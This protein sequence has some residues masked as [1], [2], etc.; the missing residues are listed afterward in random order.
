MGSD[1]RAELADYDVAGPARPRSTAVHAD[2]AEVWRPFAAAFAGHRPRPGERSRPAA[3]RCGRLRP[4]P[5]TDPAAIRAALAAEMQAARGDPAAD[6]AAVAGDA[7]RR[8]AAMTRGRRPGGSSRA[9]PGGSPAAGPA[10]LRRPGPR[11][12]SCWPC[13]RWR[14]WDRDRAAPR[15]RAPLLS[16]LRSAAA[17]TPIAALA[18]LAELARGRGRRRR[19]CAARCETSASVRPG[20]STCS[21][22]RSRWPSTGRPPDDWHVLLAGDYDA[23]RR[24]ATAGRCRRRRRDRSGHRERRAAGPR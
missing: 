14:W 23:A 18:A 10:R 22:P 3:D 24:R 5:I 15:R 12:R 9:S 8:D 21:V 11:G 17:P 1:G 16:S 20:C 4:T 7:P 19:C 13:R 6:G 2:L